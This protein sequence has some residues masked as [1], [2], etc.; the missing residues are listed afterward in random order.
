MRLRPTCPPPV[1]ARCRARKKQKE[2]VVAGITAA[3]ADLPHSTV[4]GVRVRFED[5]DGSLQGWYLGTSIQ[6]RSGAG[7]AG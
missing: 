6:H 4:D 2:E 3:F 5:E 7:H 1:S